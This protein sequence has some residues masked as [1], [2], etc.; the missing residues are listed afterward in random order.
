MTIKYNR[1][2]MFVGIVAALLGCNKYAD[3]TDVKDAA[4]KQTLAQLIKE[5]PTLSRFN[6]LLIKTG[7]DKVLEGS[8]MYTVWA[9]DNQTLQTL[10]AAVVNDADRLKQFVGNHIVNLNYYTNTPNPTLRI[11][12]LNGKYIKFTAT[13]FEDAGL[14][15]ANKYVSNGVLHTINKVVMPK[16]N[17][18]EYVSSTTYKEKTYINSL[19]YQ[20]IDSSKATQIGLDPVTGKPIYQPGTG[21]VTKNY[22][23]DR[24]GDLRNEDQEYTFILLTD[25]AVDAERTKI[26]PYVQGA[27]TDETDRLSSLHVIKDLVIKGSY[28]QAD[29]PAT[30]VSADGVTVPIDKTAIIESRATSNGMVY[31]MSAANVKLIDKIRPIKREGEQPSGFSR[32]DKSGNIAYRLRLNPNT[33]Q[34]FNDIYIFN[35]KIPLFNVRYNLPELYTVPYK[36]YWVAPNDVQTLTFKQRFAVNDPQSTSFAETDVPLKNYNQVFVG[37]YTPAKFGGITA[38]VVA[39]N[40]GVDGTNSINIDYFVLVPQL[41]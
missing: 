5:T 10:D 29:L 1:I 13:Q 3:E 14:T 38:Y 17:V 27:N 19:D 7:Y 24:V 8:K 37:D 2:I 9:P 39:A 34:Q 25:A 41:P 32:T 18:W 23:Y 21:L 22:L 4:L 31:V 6:E 30:L 35:H 15:S 11:K 40:N 36:V 33:N 12:T 28:A 20:A 26:R 16:Q